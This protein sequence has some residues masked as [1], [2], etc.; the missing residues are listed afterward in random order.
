[1]KIKIIRNCAISPTKNAKKGKT[2]AVDRAVGIELI[3][4]GAGVKAE[5]TTQDKEKAQDKD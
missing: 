5:E 3:Q 1:M 4:C 2:I